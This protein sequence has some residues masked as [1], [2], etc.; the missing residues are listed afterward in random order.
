MRRIDKTNYDDY[1]LA[2]EVNSN[3]E[4]RD[5]VTEVEKY[6]NSVLSKVLLISGLRGT[7]KSIGV[8][9]AINGKD[10]VYIMMEQGIPTSAEELMKL[11]STRSEKIIVLDE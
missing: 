1:L 5:F 6:I 11:L 10:A 2:N 7:G 9:Q 4:K 3:W 8:L